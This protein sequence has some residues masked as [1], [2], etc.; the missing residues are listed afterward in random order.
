MQKEISEKTGINQNTLSAKATRNSNWKEEEIL[1][2]NKAYNIDIYKEISNNT[3]E[4]CVSL[5][6]R[7]NISASLGHG[8]EV[9]DEKQ[10]GQYWVS[11]HLLKVLGVNKNF[12]DFIPCEGDSMFPTISGGCLLMVDKT[13]T[14]VYDGKIYCVRYNN[15]LMAKRLQFLPPNTIKVISDNKDKYEPFKVDLSKEL[16]FDFAIIGE[17]KWWGT[18]AK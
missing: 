16:D 18:L 17:V 4:N 3:S 2:L 7:G 15:Q 8:I 10:T 12:T 14:Q 13:K 1:K 9:V 6:V 11:E 5:P